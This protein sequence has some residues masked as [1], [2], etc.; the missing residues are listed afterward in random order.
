M[1]TCPKCQKAGGAYYISGTGTTFKTYGCK[2]CGKRFNTIVT[3]PL[4]PLRWDEA[5][6]VLPENYTAEDDHGDE[7]R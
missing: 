2:L 4:P 6:K 5:K 3:R 7:E 1:I